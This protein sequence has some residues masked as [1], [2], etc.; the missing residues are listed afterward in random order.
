GTRDLSFPSYRP[1]PQ[2]Y[3]LRSHGGVK[4]ETNIIKGDA[5]TLDENFK[6]HTGK[7]VKFAEV[8][9]ARN[10][11]QEDHIGP[12][13]KINDEAK[14]RRSTKPIILSTAMVINYEDLTAAYAKRAEQEEKAS[15][16]KKKLEPCG[17]SRKRREK[18]SN[19]ES[20]V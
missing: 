20:D 14:S 13:L 15:A 19:A 2:L 12:L 17:P 9:L 5:C 11:L 3:G 10:A 4:Q 8:S 7:L 6:R 16:R 18:L 1:H